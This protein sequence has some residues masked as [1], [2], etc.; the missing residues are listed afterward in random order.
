MFDKYFMK[1]LEAIDNFCDKVWNWIT[2]PRCK[3]KLKNK[4]ERK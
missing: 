3:C 1:F 4:D 2:A